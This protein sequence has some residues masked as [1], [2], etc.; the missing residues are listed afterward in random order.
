LIH[1]IMHL[2][3]DTIPHLAADERQRSSASPYDMIK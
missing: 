2:A 1:V 3:L